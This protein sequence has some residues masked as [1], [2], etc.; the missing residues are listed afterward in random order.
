MSLRICPFVERW[1]SESIIWNIPGQKQVVYKE[2]V[3]ENT[4]DFWNE[5]PLELH[6]V[7]MISHGKTAS[8]NGQVKISSGK[9]LAFC[10]VYEFVSAGR[11]SKIKEM[12]SYRI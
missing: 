8:I 4:S 7:H 12:T 11:S 2:N 10:D 3:L 9:V 5:N 1:L 6:I